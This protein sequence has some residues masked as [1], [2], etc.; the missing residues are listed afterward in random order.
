LIASPHRNDLTGLRFIKKGECPKHGLP[1]Y[2]KT[3]DVEIPIA[4]LFGNRAPYNRNLDQELVSSI[5][6]A[7]PSSNRNANDSGD[8]ATKDCGKNGL[9]DVA[10]VA[11]LICCFG[12]GLWLAF[13]DSARLIERTYDFCENIYGR[14]R[15]TILNTDQHLMILYDIYKTYLHQVGLRRLSGIYGCET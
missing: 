5:A 13:T 15:K 9:K 7:L 10:Q 8:K 4:L 6:V 3:V 12:I 14:I 11:L 2:V 1:D